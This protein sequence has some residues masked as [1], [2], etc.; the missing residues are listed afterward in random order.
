MMADL[1]VKKWRRGDGTISDR[2]VNSF[3]YIYMNY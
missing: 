3:E 2:E 1:R